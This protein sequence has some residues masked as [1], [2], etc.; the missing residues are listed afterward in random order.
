MVVFCYYKKER[1][2]TVRMHAIVAK[3]FKTVSNEVVWQLYLRW[4]HPLCNYQIF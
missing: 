1:I 2:S 4:I 3:K